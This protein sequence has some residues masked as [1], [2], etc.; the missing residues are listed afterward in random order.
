MAAAIRLSQQHGC[1]LDYL[2][3][4]GVQGRRNVETKR[5]GGLEIDDQLE[6][7]R[8]HHRQITGFDAAE[9]AAG[10]DAGLA[11]GIREIGS[12]A[13]QPS[14]F[15]ELAERIDRYQARTCG[16]PNDVLATGHIEWVAADKQRVGALPGKRYEGRFDLGEHAG[17]EHP[18]LQS[19]SLRRRLHLANFRNGV[20]T[21]R[22]GKHRDGGRLGNEITHKLQPLLSELSR[23]EHHARG[24]ASGPI[25]ARDKPG[26]DWIEA[27]N[28]DDRDRR[29][30]D[31]C[32]QRS[33]RP[34]RHDQ[35]HRTPDHFAGQCWQ[36][37]VL[38]I[39]KAVVDCD[40]AAVDISGLDKAALERSHHVT[41]LRL[42][43]GAEESDHRHHRLLRAGS[44]RPRGRRS[45]EQRDELP[46]L[47]SI[48]SLANA[49]SRSGTLRP[50][51]FAVL[52]LSTSSYLVGACTGRSPGFSPLRMRSTYSAERRNWSTKSGP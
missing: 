9:N 49:S 12:V 16:K 39:G 24:I 38:A 20:W 5:L 15:G 48:T 30:G 46:S 51:T 31:L 7:G 29:G 43:D 41:G 13:D 52:R 44:N 14:R 36:A 26:A 42:R 11:I 37:I 47:H 19:V 33:W 50:S 3:G 8:L 2:V 35:R 21:H 22:I 25:E 4:A 40:V 34:A 28:E 6:R 27:H 10:I 45:A 1:S 32:G 18:Q 17:V 23:D